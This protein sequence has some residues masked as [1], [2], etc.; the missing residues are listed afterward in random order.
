MVLFT[1]FFEKIIN[2]PARDLSGISENTFFLLYFN[3]GSLPELSSADLT[4]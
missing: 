3:G 2:N 4:A 1:F